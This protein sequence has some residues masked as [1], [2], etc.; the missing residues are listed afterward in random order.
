MPLNLGRSSVSC[1]TAAQRLLKKVKL[2]IDGIVEEKSGGID[3]SVNENS[4]KMGKGDS[5][6]TCK[7]E[8]NDDLVEMV[9]NPGSL[10]PLGSQLKLQ[11]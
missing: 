2:G 6:P 3:S 5:L 10:I 8:E 9:V 11:S 4:V 7:E 1:S